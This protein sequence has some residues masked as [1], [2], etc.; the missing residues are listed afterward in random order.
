MEIEICIAE[1]WNILPR[2][3]ALLETMFCCKSIHS[4]VVDSIARQWTD[5]SS[6]VLVKREQHTILVQEFQRV[7]MARG[8]S[9]EFYVPVVT[10]SLKQMIVGFQIVG[11][12]VDDLGSGCQPF[13]VALTGSTNHRQALE[14]AC[15]SWRPQCKS[16]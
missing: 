5:C 4:N 7:C 10:A 13:M 14:A 12:G 3:Q 11:H 15:N 6:G 1:V 9:M 16:R 2:R 8:L